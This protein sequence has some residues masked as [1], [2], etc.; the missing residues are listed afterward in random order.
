MSFYRNSEL[1]VNRAAEKVLMHQENDGAHTR[2][3]V[4]SILVYSRKNITLYAVRIWVSKG[5]V[6]RKGLVFGLNSVIG[7]SGGR[8]RHKH[9]VEHL[10]LVCWRWKRDEGPFPARAR[11]MLVEDRQDRKYNVVS[12]KFSEKQRLLRKGSLAF[13]WKQLILSRRH[14][15]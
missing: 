15:F 3:W 7:L 13:K 8:C 1:A 2:S 5:S 6:L 14:I 12:F 10:L 9:Y 4:Q 11:S